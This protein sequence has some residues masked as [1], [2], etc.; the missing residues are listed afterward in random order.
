MHTNPNVTITEC[1]LSSFAFRFHQ[2]VIV[3]LS[4]VLCDMCQSLH[5]TAAWS[6]REVR[7]S[8]GAVSDKA[9][10]V[11]LESETLQ[12]LCTV[13]F[14]L[15]SAWFCSVTVPWIRYVK[16]LVS[17]VVRL[18]WW[19]WYL[20]CNVFLPLLH[21]W[22]ERRGGRRQLLAV[23]TGDVRSTGEHLLHGADP[24]QDPRG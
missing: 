12:L 18:L 17:R 15:F 22:K 7:R 4:S 11:R 10:E 19:L 23:W 14:P 20:P 8:I 13:L 24:I 16:R 1:I 6:N 3:I 21:R 9:R 2:K 5:M